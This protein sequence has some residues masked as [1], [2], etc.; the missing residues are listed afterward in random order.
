M[1]NNIYARAYTEVL[2][3]LK[4]FPDEEYKKIPIEKIN[5][6]KSHMDKNYKFT[7]NPEMDLANQNISKE[8]NA[9]IVT[10]FRDY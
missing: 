9:I 2:E 1:V 6:Y 7:I 4:H 5:F 3:I 8:A 10:L